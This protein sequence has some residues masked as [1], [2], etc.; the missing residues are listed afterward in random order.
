MYENY[1]YSQFKDL[2]DKEK[3]KALEEILP[4]F[5]GNTKELADYW[6]VPPIVTRNAYKRLVEGE[7]VGRVKVIQNAD[8]TEEKPKRKYERKNNT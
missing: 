4:I 6:G 2:K 7:H 1:T 8:T 3:K 5:K